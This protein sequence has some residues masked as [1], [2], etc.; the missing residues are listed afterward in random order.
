MRTVLA[1]FL[2][3]CSSFAHATKLREE[4]RQAFSRYDQQLQQRFQR[5]LKSPSFHSAKQG[6]VAIA[7][8][9]GVP[10]IPGGIIHDWVGV[11]F[12]PGTT[13]AKALALLEDY[14]HHKD[15][16]KSEVVDSR[17]LSQ[18]GD[19]FRSYMRFYKKKIIGVTL[20]TEH[21]A[22]WVQTSPTTAY[23]ISHSTKIAEVEDAGTNHEREKPPG[24]DNGFLWALNSYWT[25]VQ[26][27]GGV[28]VQCEAVSLTRDIPSGLGWIVKPFITEVPK[29]SLHN[30][31][32]STRRALISGR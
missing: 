9:P 18:K 26:K 4:T 28:Y 31:L 11:V 17:L 29:E 14:D 21:L 13:L 22:R 12:V 25:L 19:E 27:D 2:L 3:L 23:S 32:D 6:E 30:T 20:N 7:A 1:I 15:V 24:D 10:E 16:Y 5:A 8:V